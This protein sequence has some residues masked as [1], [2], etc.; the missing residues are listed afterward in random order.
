M[1]EDDH[2]EGCTCGIPEG[3]ILTNIFCVAEYMSPDGNL[4]K[5]DMSHDGSDGPIDADKA[6]AMAEWGKALYMA[7]TLAAVL[8]E[9]FGFEEIEE[10]KE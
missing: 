8:A 1:S 6:V 7:P 4:W 5:T 3:S 10:G 9:M 2:P